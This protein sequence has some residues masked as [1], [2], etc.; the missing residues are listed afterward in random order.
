MPVY[1]EKPFVEQKAKSEYH[2][3]VKQGNIF[4][5]KR[6]EYTILV[7]PINFILD[8]IDRKDTPQRVQRIVKRLKMARKKILVDYDLKKLHKIQ[9]RSTHAR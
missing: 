4:L 8:C 9:L 1:Y 2:Y 7:E 6:R 5:K 3:M